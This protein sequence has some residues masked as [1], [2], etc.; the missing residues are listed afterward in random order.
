M[1]AV[2]CPVDTPPGSSRLK[3]LRVM[4]NIR[5]LIA[6]EDGSTL[7][8]QETRVL[9]LV[10]WGFTNK[11]IAARLRIS[12]KTVETYRSRLQGKLKIKSRPALVLFAPKHG[13]LQVG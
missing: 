11:E 7:S 12:V 8:E 3:R 6:D 10:A 1:A 5:I 13:W 2:R 9:R 4:K